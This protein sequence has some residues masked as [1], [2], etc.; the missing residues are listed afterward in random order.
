MYT[1]CKFHE[2]YLTKEIIIGHK[3]LDKKRWDRRKDNKCPYIS[4]KLKPDHKRKI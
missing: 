2:I 3:C 4:V 1:Y